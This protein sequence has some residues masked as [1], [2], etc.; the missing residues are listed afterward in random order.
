MA[1]A[2]D[3]PH[4]VIAGMMGAGKTTT[5]RALASALGR[6][7][8]DS[9]RDIEERTGRTGAEIAERLGVDGLHRLEATVLLEALSNDVPSVVSAAGSA[10]E[11]EA[12]R[13]ALAERA[14][15][16]VIRATAE[17]LHERARRGHHRRPMSRREIDTLLE[18]REPLLT[19]IADLTL[20]ASHPPQELVKAIV[21]HLGRGRRPA[22][23]RSPLG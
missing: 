20:D 5:G 23:D 11:D 12:C 9:D 21:A 1:G 10:I 6:P 15:V 4:V 19:Q 2:G 22:G 13:V 18:R 14:T 17:Q 16:V 8:R 7:H 3:R